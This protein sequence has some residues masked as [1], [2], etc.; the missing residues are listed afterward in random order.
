[1]LSLLYGSI[2]MSVH[3][4]WKKHYFGK[5]TRLLFNMMSR[6]VHGPQSLSAV[7]LEPRKVKSITIST[8][9]SSCC[10]EVMEQEASNVKGILKEHGYQLE[11]APKG[12]S[13]DN[14]SRSINSDINYNN[15]INHRVNEVYLIVPRK[16]S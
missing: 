2:L 6:F 15:R 16:C 9:P 7:I 11:G 8:F 13:W 12:Q 1:M 3:D 10:H 4:Y 5:V 14:L